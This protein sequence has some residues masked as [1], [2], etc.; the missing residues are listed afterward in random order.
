MHNHGRVENTRQQ[1]GCVSKLIYLM[2][3]LLSSFVAIYVLLFFGFEMIRCGPILVVV[4]QAMAFIG[5]LSLL[6]ATVSVRT[7]ARLVS[8]LHVSETRAGRHIRDNI[9]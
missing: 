1:C 7:V 5:S 9:N 6:P 2:M 4:V 3:D 8:S